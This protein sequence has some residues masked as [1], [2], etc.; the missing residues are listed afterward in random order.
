MRLDGPAC[1]RCAQPL[2]TVAL[3]ARCISYTAGLSTTVSVFQF[4]GPVRSA[5]HALKYRDLRAIAPVLG[6]LMAAD[7]RVARLEADVVVPVPMHGKRLRTRGYNQAELLARQ[8]ARQL[9]LGVDSRSLRRVAE[10][11]PQARASSEAEREQQVRGAFAATSSIAGRRVLL[12]DD[13]ATTGST[14]RECGRVLM[15]A[16]AAEVSALVLAR[17]V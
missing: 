1:P 6:S 8:V 7:L 3:C 2:G 10:T 16:G 15:A 5:V 14:L 17:E 13:V 4:G 12:I 11:P 9:K